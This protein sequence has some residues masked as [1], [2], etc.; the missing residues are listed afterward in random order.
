MASTTA[1]VSLGGVTAVGDGATIDFATAKRVVTAVIVPSAGAQN[2][3]VLVSASQDSANWV[4]IAQVEVTDG[5][6]LSYEHTN[7]AYRY[8]RASVLKRIDLG[9]VVVTFMEAG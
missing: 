9:S 5:R 3:F 2:G 6:V 7:G 1:L 8:W 4:P